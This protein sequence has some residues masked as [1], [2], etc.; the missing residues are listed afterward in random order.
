[1]SFAWTAGMANPEV[2]RGQLVVKDNT[3]KLAAGQTFKKGELIRI[4]SAGTIAVA[5]INSDTTGPVHGMALANAATT[6]VPAEQTFGEG[7]FFPVALFDK[8]T[9]ILIQLAAG[10]DQNDVTIGT[11]TALAVASNKWT[12]TNSA[13]KGI[14]MIVD[15]ESQSAWFDEKAN[16][17]LDGSRIVIKFS[18]ANLEARGA[19]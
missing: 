19:L 5:A 8:D 17:S 6:A 10:V 15:K 3:Y 11:S 16:A 7:D 9:E 13:T 14:A 12:A 1:M 18:Q 2:L 4:T